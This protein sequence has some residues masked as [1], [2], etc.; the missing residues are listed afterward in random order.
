M[1]LG[2]IT[3]ALGDWIRGGQTRQ[4]ARATHILP[5]C[6]PVLSE[7][8]AKPA[9]QPTRQLTRTLKPAW[10]ATRQPTRTP[11]TII[12]RRL[13]DKPATEHALRLLGELR[14]H[15]LPNGEHVTHEII[16]EIYADMLLELGWAELP[17]QTVAPHGYALVKCETA[18]FKP[19]A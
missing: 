1:L 7:A 17:W 11:S 19:E 12:S 13:E 5:M 6:K 18:V 16:R 9:R 2:G 14:A 8:P 4:P 3:E 15:P 10:Q